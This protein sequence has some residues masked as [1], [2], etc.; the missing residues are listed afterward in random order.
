M[1]EQAVIADGET[2]AGHEPHAEKQGN[3]ERAGRTVEQ[4][5][6]C[7]Q[8]P[9]KRQHVEQDE[10]LPLQPVKMPAP[11]DAVVAGPLHGAKFHNSQRG[12]CTQPAFLPQP[13]GT[14]IAAW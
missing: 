10:V 11:D 12:T 4:Q 5:A 13:H 7:D 3:V 2:E 8:G 14:G 9:K 6:Q 1:R